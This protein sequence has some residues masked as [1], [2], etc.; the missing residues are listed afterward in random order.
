M[1]PVR[2]NQEVLPSERELIKLDLEVTI[3][4][5]NVHY[6]KDILKLDSND[7]ELPHDM[8]GK[9]NKLDHEVAIKLGLQFLPNGNKLYRNLIMAGVELHR[10]QYHHR[11]WENPSPV[12]PKDSRKLSAI[13][14][15]CSMLEPLESRKY[16]QDGVLT[17]EQIKQRITEKSAPHQ[18]SWME[19]IYREMRKIKQPN[20]KEITSLS[21]IPKEGISP[22]M[23]DAIV[24]RAYEALRELEKHGYNFYKNSERYIR[25][26]LK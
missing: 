2:H 7:P 10:Q 15:I 21:K 20:L 8:K 18:V 5:F 25:E 17:W 14:A 22:E 23:R 3:H 12:V 11:M 24:D 13:D 4:S 9:Y 26:V 16:Q 6:Y 19:E 1:H